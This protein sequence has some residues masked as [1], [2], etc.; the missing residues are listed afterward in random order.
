M[1]ALHHT[2]PKE[3]T[4]KSR[5]SASWYLLP[6]FVT[7][8]AGTY[9]LKAYSQQDNTP[10]RVTTIAGINK[11]KITVNFQD[12]TLRDAL[13]TLFQKAPVNHVTVLTG[14]IDGQINFATKDVP[15]EGA[16]V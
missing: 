10:A 6:V 8:C 12:A 13:K 14:G 4:M 11:R 5:M 7:A 9:T 1:P 16:L 2:P 15:F 3:F